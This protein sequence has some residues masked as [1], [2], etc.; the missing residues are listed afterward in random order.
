MFALAQ[1]ANLRYSGWAGAKTTEGYS[2]A[3]L[4]FFL[5]FSHAPHEDGVDHGS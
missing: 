5:D 4:S 3:N 1:V 2:I